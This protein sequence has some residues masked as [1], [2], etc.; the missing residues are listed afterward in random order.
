MFHGDARWKKKKKKKK[1]TPVGVTTE[2][3]SRTLELTEKSFKK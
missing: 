2:M 3:H 1:K